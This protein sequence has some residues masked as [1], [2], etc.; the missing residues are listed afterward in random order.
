MVL[1]M[2]DD[3]LLRIK[4]LLASGIPI[5]KE[6]AD[7]LIL[8]IDLFNSGQCKTLCK[9]LGLR[10]TGHSSPATREKITRRDSWIKYIATRYE[11]S[12]WTVAT[13]I[14]TKATLYPHISNVQERAVYGY[15]LAIDPKLLSRDMIFKILQ[16]N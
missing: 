6:L 11:G 12:N 7:W 3:D 9:A 16:N 14:K 13:E 15:L 2:T 5:P 4:T 8:G 10:S 1:K